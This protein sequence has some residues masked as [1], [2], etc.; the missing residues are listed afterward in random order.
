MDDLELPPPPLI[1]PVVVRQTADEVAGQDWALVLAS[2]GI[3]HRLEA[4][5]RGT[6][7]RLLLFVGEGDLP[8]AARALDAYD[9]EARVPDAAAAASWEGRSALGVAVA[10]V[11]LAFQIVAGSRDAA[12]PS[13]WFSAG[14]AASDAILHGEWWRA[15]TAMTLHADLSHL[16]GNVVA[17]L[18]FIAAAGRWLGT[19]L[20]AAL[21]VTAGAAA[22]LLTAAVR[23]PGHLSIGASTA[24]FA[25]LGIMAGLQVVRHFRIGPLRRRAWLPIGAGLALFAMLG[26]GQHADVAAHLFGL[27]T[28]CVL[29]LGAALLLRRRP[30]WLAQGA[31][32]LAAAAAVAGSWL[33]AFRA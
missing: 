22:N 15:V 26:V 1:L 10:I 4:S 21:I 23:G 11:L 9:A 31:L 29:G 18:I 7:R 16:F 30:G 28:G 24:T 19:G 2:A 13:A 25:A 12:Q 20:A 5:G 27:G 6:D 32:A 17:S 3:A 14:A 33:L 8:A